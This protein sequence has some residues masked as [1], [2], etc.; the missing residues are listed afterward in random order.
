MKRF[1]L[2]ALSFF[3]LFSASS[4]FKDNDDD[5]ISASEI[6]D[7]VWKGMNFFY[8]Y[9]DEIPNLANDRFSSDEEYAEYLN[10]FAQPEDLF[11][12]LL[13]QPQTVDRFS[14]IVPNY[15]ELEQL[16]QGTTLN[17]GMVFGLVRVPNDASAIF[18]YVRYV[19]PNT[20]AES[21]GLTRGVIFDGVDGTPL[22]DSNFRS[23]LFGENTSYTINIADYNDN[24]TATTS[25]D[26]ITST[27]ASVSLTKEVYTENPILINDIIEIGGKKIGYL[28]YNGF[29]FE[30][31]PVTELNQA[32]DDFGNANIDDLVLDLR[33][34]GGGSVSTAIWLSSMITGQF[35]GQPLFE[36]NWNSDIQSF[37]E[38][39]NPDLLV[40]PFVDTIVKTDGDG[41]VVFQQD[42]N[43][44]NLGKVYILTTSRTASASELVI[45]G[46]RPYIDVIQI[47][48]N[49]T[50]KPQASRTVYDSE[51]FGRANANPNH[52][53]AIQPLI[54][55]SANA[56]GFSSYYN[57]LAPSTGFELNENFG[58]LGTL[59]DIN[60]PLLARAIEDITG[61][62]RS[63]TPEFEGLEVMAEQNF[64]QPFA[65]EMFDNRPS[66]ALKRKE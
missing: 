21:Q 55:E 56:S 18:G 57:G 47:G 48:D 14:A 36:E 8:V 5:L 37:F 41:N 23:L 63:F 15:F 1:N 2:F 40:N 59:G 24:G 62:G 51:D 50:G 30:D 64:N 7:F 19:L 66:K 54:Y 10:G 33:Y 17:N 16:L 34:N 61:A 42:I 31:G 6:N 20:S 60:E 39:E 44:L 22:T 38:T 35:T 52:T 53:Y 12:S 13:F 4:C 27:D 32:F 28:M 46:L 3:V 26:T 43:S 58:N 45:N 29:R 49:T 25:D 9:K 11:N 65:T